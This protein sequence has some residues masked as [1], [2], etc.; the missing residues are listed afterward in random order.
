MKDMKTKFINFTT[1]LLIFAGNF[2]S[3]SEKIQEDPFLTV[4]KTQIDAEADAVTCS[5]AVSSNREWTVAVED[6]DNHAWCKLTNTSGKGNGDITIK[7][8]INPTLTARNAT[9]IISSGSLDNVLIDIN[10]AFD[11]SGVRYYG[12]TILPGACFPVMKDKYT[13]PIVP[14]M[15]EWNNFTGNH[16]EEFCQLPDNILKSISTP[17]LIDAL[18]HEPFF[19]T[20]YGL[21]SNLSALK[22]YS[23]YNLFNSAIELFQREDA[24]DAL[25]AYY[26]L[27]CFDC[28]TNFGIIGECTR[29][30]GLECLFTKQEILS[31]I[32]HK[33]KK[34][35]VAALL[36]NYEQWTDNKDCICPMVYLMFADEYPPIVKYSQDYP[37]MFNYALN[38]LSRYYNQIDLFVSYA[39]NFIND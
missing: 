23:H 4:D 39:K 3:C 34:Q 24:G 16:I 38:G 35:A 20:F 6:A 21:S 15:P 22:W 36:A 17:G 11:N 10:Q 7:L 26:S 27:V 5:I 37:E 19:D 8:S 30:M 9:V 13:Y 29:I 12:L 14:G 18:I 28:V 25:V 1:I 33:G 31:K 32:S 2:Y